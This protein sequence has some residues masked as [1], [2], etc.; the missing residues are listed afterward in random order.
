MLCGF[1]DVDAL[2]NA[3]HAMTGLVTYSGPLH[4]FFGQKKDFGYTKEHFIKA[5]KDDRPFKLEA[6]K[7]WSDDD[8]ASDQENRNLLPNVGLQVVQYGTATRRIVGGNLCTLNLLQGTQYM[9]DLNDVVLFLEEAKF[10]NPS[11]VDRDLQSLVQQK[12]FKANGF[13]M[14]R[15]QPGTMTDKQLLE[16][17]RSKKELNNIPIITNANFGHTNPKGTIPVG[18]TAHIEAS[19]QHAEIIFLEH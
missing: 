9:P 17:L 12:G 1:S 3:V 2:V 10:S 4:I 7:Y 8:W 5:T 11:Q 13:V 19:N 6:N 18:D 14:G 16:I 15:F